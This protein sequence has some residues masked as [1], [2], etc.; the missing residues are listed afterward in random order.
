MRGHSSLLHSSTRD[1]SRPSD[2]RS[3]DD[4]SRASEQGLAQHFGGFWGYRAE[5]EVRRDQ[6]GGFDGGSSCWMGFGQ[7]LGDWGDVDEVQS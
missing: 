2:C 6:L 5:C 3:Y 7:D 4:A 1:S